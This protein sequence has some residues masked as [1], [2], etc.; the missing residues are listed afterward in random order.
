MIKTD[1]STAI[2]KIQK[3]ISQIQSFESLGPNSQALK[4]WQRDTEHI[5]ENIFGNGSH[6]LNTFAKI[7]YRPPIRLFSSSI[8]DE[9]SF[10]LD[11][12][13]KQ[14]EEA[15]T[16]L[17]SIVNEIEEF[18]RDSSNGSSSVGINEVVELKPNFFGLGLNINALIK[19]YFR[20][21]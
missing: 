2:E 20:K 7:K 17:Q 18:W 11:Y 15:K 1:R 3:Q 21:Q 4:D 14:L 16:V 10:Q 19:K 6:Q 8:N 9:A 12:L 5:L 13:K